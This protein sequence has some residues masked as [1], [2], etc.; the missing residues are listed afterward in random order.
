M[1]IDVDKW[2]A[3]KIVFWLVTFNIVKPIGLSQ[4]EL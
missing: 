3:T 4:A 2:Y 1:L